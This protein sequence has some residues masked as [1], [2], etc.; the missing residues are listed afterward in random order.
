[1][2]KAK[3]N[4]EPLV[5]LK[6]QAYKAIQDAIERVATQTRD[7]SI[8]RRSAEKDLVKARFI[9]HLGDYAKA[10]QKADEICP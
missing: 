10:K 7:Y 5:P 9:Y 8:R 2:N 4:P 3:N 1:M 6:S